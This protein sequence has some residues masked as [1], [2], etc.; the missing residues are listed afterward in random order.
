MNNNYYEI[1]HFSS[2]NDFILEY[3]IKENSHDCKDSIIKVF[4][5]KGIDF[6]IKNYFKDEKINEI[7]NN[8]NKSIAYICTIKEDEKNLYS[9]E[10][11]NY[12]NQIISI[13]VSIFSFE[14]I[15]K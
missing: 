3:L 6:L 7:T 11:I 13:L 12:I 15:K 14:G 5:D 2:N 10:D 9:D 1:G 8:K 4:N